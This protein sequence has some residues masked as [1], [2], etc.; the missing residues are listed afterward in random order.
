M[1]QV[2][3]TDST[4]KLCMYE[5]N[6]Y[7]SVIYNNIRSASRSRKTEV[8]QANVHEISVIVTSASYY[9]SRA[10]I[11]MI[12]VSIN[13]HSEKKVRRERRV[14]NKDRVNAR[15]STDYW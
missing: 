1:V 4:Y 10:I 3:K 9:H 12:Y 7:N 15:F 11:I 2:Y 14:V 5:S 8:T 6:H 13:T